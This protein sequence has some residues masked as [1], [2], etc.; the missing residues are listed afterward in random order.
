MKPEGNRAGLIVGQPCIAMYTDKLLVS[1]S[2]RSAT[3]IQIHN[4]E[5]LTAV[6]GVL[7]SSCVVCGCEE[8]GVRTDGL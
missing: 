8:L 1:K 7:K 3:E 6:E 4:S 5:V 2:Q